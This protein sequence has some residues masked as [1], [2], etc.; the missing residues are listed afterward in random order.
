MIILMNLRKN[1]MK[2]KQTVMIQNIYD[3]ET[4]ND[5]S[6]ENKTENIKINENTMK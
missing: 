1:L 2:K 3:E 6:E 5:D 4:I